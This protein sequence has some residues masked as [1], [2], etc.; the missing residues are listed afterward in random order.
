MFKILSYPIKDGEP[1]WPGNPTCSLQSHTSIAKGDTANTA[2]IHLLITTVLI[3]TVL[4]TL[5][6]MAFL[7]TRSPWSVSS[8]RSH[9]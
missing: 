7:W 3:W 2:T 4:C 9:L 6:Q 5:I 8:I 1:T